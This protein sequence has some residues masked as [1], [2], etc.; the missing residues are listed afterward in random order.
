MSGNQARR[1]DDKRKSG[2]GDNSAVTV[3][4]TDGTGPRLADLFNDRRRKNIG[5]GKRSF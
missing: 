1:A 5:Q 2:Y 3:Q 4:D